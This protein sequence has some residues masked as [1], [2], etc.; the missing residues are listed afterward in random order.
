MGSNGAW[1]RG[2]ARY[3]AT[4][5]GLHWLIAF[6]IFAA[7]GLGWCGFAQYLIYSKL[8]WTEFSIYWKRSRNI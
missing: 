5:I 7:F 6:G 2:E 8:L 3:T 1:P 4:A